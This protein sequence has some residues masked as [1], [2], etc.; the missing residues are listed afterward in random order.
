MLLS[1]VPG[2]KKRGGAEIEGNVVTT[3]V[4][5]PQFMYARR[6]E[7][8]GRAVRSLAAMEVPSTGYTNF[9]AKQGTELF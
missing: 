3:G 9:P 4:V 8:Y 1:F 5:A 6:N 7:G 2:E